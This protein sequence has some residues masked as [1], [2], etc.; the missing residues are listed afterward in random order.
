VTGS[1][2]TR[3]DEYL[4]DPGQASLG[5]KKRGRGDVEI[6]GLI[7]RRDKNLDFAAC[8]SP[9]ELWAKWASRTLESR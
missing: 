9:I 2:E 5:I 6:K 1:T 4:R 7:S 3:V 8:T